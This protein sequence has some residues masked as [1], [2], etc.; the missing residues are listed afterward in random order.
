MSPD[1]GAMFPNKSVRLDRTLRLVTTG[2]ILDASPT[3][4]R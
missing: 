2:N 3:M 4:G 1:W